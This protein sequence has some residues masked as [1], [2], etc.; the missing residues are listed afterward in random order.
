[1]KKPSTVQHVV[2]MTALVFAVAGCSQKAKNSQAAAATAK[3]PM[4]SSLKA[5]A[6]ISP[7][8]GYEVSGVVYFA[9]TPDGVKVTGK[10]DHL[11]PGKHGFHV[12]EA[13]DCTGPD[14]KTAGGH[15]NPDNMPHGGPTS[16]QRHV[17]D[18]GNIVAD[19][20]GSAV[21]NMVDTVIALEGPHSIIGR[22]IIVHAGEDDLTSQPSGDAGPRVACGVIGYAEGSGE[23]VAS[24][25]ATK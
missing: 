13:G 24:N 6:A 11:T 12:H 22:S 1:M 9:Q 15:F 14:A 10:I 8:Q 2:L 17:G 19:A 3:T 21:I 20:N 18:L 16:A 4:H 23:N 5:V 25:P 7:T